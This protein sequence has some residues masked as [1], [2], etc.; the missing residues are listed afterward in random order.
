VGHTLKSW[1]SIAP[2]PREHGFLMINLMFLGIGHMGPL[3]QISSI[4]IPNEET[5]P[6]QGFN[7]F[8]LPELYHEMVKDLGLEI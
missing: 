5:S 8:I 1:T 2:K 3:E 4:H 6:F 7:F